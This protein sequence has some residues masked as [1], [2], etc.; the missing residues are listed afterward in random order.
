MVY[1]IS[2]ETCGEYAV[3]DIQ[4]NSCWCSCVLD[5]YALIPDELVSG[6]LATRGYCDI[7]LNEE[8][9][10]VVSFSARE[11]PLVPIVPVPSLILTEY[12]DY[13]NTFPTNPKKGQLFFTPD[14]LD[15]TPD[16]GDFE[17]YDRS[18]QHYAESSI[19]V[20]KAIY[21]STYNIVFVNA[22]VELCY[23]PGTVDEN[24]IRK[25]SSVFFYTNLST[26]YLPIANK[27]ICA[28]SSD[29]KIACYGDPNGDIT[30]EVL[31]DIDTYDGVY[32]GY[33]NFFY[34]CNGS[35]VSLPTIPKEEY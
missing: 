29:G 6:I 32:T 24:T 30:I 21:S 15:I 19:N 25:D 20:R 14:A 7:T 2:K 31:A 34:F 10:E 5:G 16:P 28:I 22:E 8:G 35:L 18:I 4:T 23:N 9:T 13:G 27:G 11:I 12:A 17:L 26:E 1:V 3:R 33:L